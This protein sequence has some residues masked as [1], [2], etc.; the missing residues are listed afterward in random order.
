[1]RIKNDA[2]R[3]SGLLKT[4]DETQLVVLEVVDEGC[5]PIK[6]KKLSGQIKAG[7]TGVPSHAIKRKEHAENVVTCASRPRGLYEIIQGLNDQQRNDVRSVGFGGLLHLQLNKC[8]NHKMIQWLVEHFNHSSR[9]LDLDSIRSFVIIADD[10]H[11]VFMLPRNP[12][13]PVVKYG[14]K[15]ET[16]LLLR[17]KEK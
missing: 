5:N 7:A 17:V 12:G 15:A 3:G 4:S 11:D 10:V 1:M 13:V 2:S 9:M 8:S 16:S 14:K 6:K